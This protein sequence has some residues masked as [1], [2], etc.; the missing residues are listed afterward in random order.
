[1]RVLVAT[2]AGAGHFGPLVPVARALQQGGHRVVVA[3]PAS[4]AEEVARTGLVHLPFADVDP[5][6]LRPVMARLP[7]SSTQETD[8]VVLS[9]VLG[10]L[11]AQAAYPGVAETIDVWRP[12]LVLREPVELASLAAALAA[13]VPHA[14]VAT[15]VTRLVDLVAVHLEEP[16]LELDALAGLPPGC[17]ASTLAG[18]PTFTS[19]PQVLDDALG[20]VP[21][22]GPLVRYREPLEAGCGVLPG[23]WGDP[24]LPLV[25]VT[26]GSAAGR[27]PHLAGLHP[28]A[29]D[30]LA[31]L[32]VRVLMT[33]GAGVDPDTLHVPANA[34]VQQWWPQADVLPQAAAVVGHGGFGTTLA[35]LAAG[36]PQ[37]V[38]PLLTSD[39]V[40]NAEHV[41]ACGAGVVVPGGVDGVAGLAEAVEEVLRERRYAA[42]A[43]R[44]A[45]EIAALPP[46]ARIVPLLEDLAAGVSAG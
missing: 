32:P 22:R 39:R 2:T 6:V 19:V 42:A 8:R 40:V 1:M 35:A 5:A 14:L 10:R 23:R 16:L 26:F 18:A 7:G 45:A 27:M 24:R 15:H 20:P 30:A 13:G 28:A 33:T 3:A 31:D 43:R 41:A 25:H 29:L 36:V 11:A 9:E 4:Y 12:D 21:R 38:L 37:V 34:S 44:V 46:A 17:C